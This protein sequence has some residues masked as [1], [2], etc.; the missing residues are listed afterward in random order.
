MTYIFVDK[1]SHF[2]TWKWSEIFTLQPVQILFIYDLIFTDDLF[3]TDSKED[4]DI[5]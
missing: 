4:P 1:M 2:F 5:N 3:F